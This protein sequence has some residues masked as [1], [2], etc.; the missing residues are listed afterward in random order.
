MSINLIERFGTQRNPELTPE[1]WDAFVREVALA[2][3]RVLGEAQSI[4]ETRAQLIQTTL[5]RVNE[6]IEPAFERALV[7]QTG[8]F[9]DADIDDETEVEFTEG[10]QTLLIAE[11]KRDIFR[12][13][14]FVALTRTSTTTDL[15]IAQ[16][17]SY[18]AA[19]G[20]LVVD[21][22]AV[23]G[24]GGTFSDVRVVATA[25]SVQAQHQFLS[26]AKA[27]RDAADD[28]R[29]AAEGAAQ[30]AAEDALATA[31][32][33]LQTGL[34]RIQTGLDRIA[35][36]GSA[37]AA[38]TFNPAHFYLKTETLSEAEIASAI[39][40]AID[41]LLS[42]APGALDTLQE[43]AAALGNDADFAAT[44]ISALALKANTAD[45]GALAV[46]A[47]VNNSDWSGD[48]LAV[49][50][51][52]TGASS[53]ETALSNLGGQA[54]SEKG[55][56]NGY[57]SL[58]GDGLIPPS[59]ISVPVPAYGA[60]GSYVIAGSTAFPSGSPGSPGDLVAGSTL[61]WIGGGFT[62]I[63]G[64]TSGNTGSTPA[65]LS[66]SGTWR[67]MTHTQT[68]TGNLS[69]GLYLRTV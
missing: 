51:G 56:A 26:E 3:N 38:A 63:N 30:G 24:E 1:L 8:G 19:T 17:L 35:A 55:V 11:D 21:I 52:G 61:R 66:L 23:I 62:T 7:Y 4:S 47:N 12:P 43:L 60:V 45:L 2:L 68:T 65:S 57:A 13:T 22:V 41:G 10:E 34:D 42:G 5:F 33:R 48:D 46:K 39:S 32:D 15:A 14:P 69:L 58:D 9:L 27:A 18:D 6:L 20:A 37:A 31:A 64:G 67:L 44:I 40:A 59:Q 25:G 29:V 54:V 36:E 16:A 28:D 49:E 50:H 53:A